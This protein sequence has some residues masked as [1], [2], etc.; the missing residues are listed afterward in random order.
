MRGM[1]AIKKS[2]SGVLVTFE[3]ELLYKIIKKRFT[4]LLE[5]FKKVYKIHKVWSSNL[6]L[7]NHKTHK[8]KNYK[9]T[10][11]KKRVTKALCELCVNLC[12]RS[13]KN[14]KP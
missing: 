14:Y 1:L 12:E 13:S 11:I 2:K 6:I 7:N 8:A 5:K 3:F 10:Q 9:K 4:K